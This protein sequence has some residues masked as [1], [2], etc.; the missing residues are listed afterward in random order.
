MF[1]ARAGEAPLET[2][3]IAAVASG[4]ALAE[5]WGVPARRVDFHDLKGDLEALAALSGARLEFRAAAPSWAHPGRAAEVLRDGTVVGAIAELHP[6]LQQA[7]DLD[8]P[9]VAFELDL[10]AVTPRALPRAGTLSKFP[11]VRRDLAFIVADSVSWSELEATASAAAGPFLKALHLFDV[12]AGKGVETGFKSVAMGLIL[13][14]ASR[15]LVDRDVDAV[16]ASV[17]DA[18]AVAHGARIRG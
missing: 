2:P 16:V 15:T 14:D 7:L 1:S 10:A 11:S 4:D 17:T 6:R 13:Q 9:V 3:R 5:Q 12:Y 8:H 18:V